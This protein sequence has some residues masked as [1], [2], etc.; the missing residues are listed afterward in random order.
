MNK[1]NYMT[2]RDQ[3]YEQ[4]NTYYDESYKCN[5]IK[6][7]NYEL[8]ETCCPLECFIYEGHYLCMACMPGC[9]TG[10]GWNELEFRDSNEE[11]VICL[12]NN[13]KQVKFPT[14]CGHW[15]CLSCSKNILFL[16]ETRY[17]LSP[18]PFGCSS[19]PNNC[20][21]PIKGKQ[22]YCEE[23]TE[24]QDKW[25]QDF[26]LEYKKW[27]DSENLSIDQGE[28]IPGSVFG[29]CTCPLCKKKYK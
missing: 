12:E 24:I 7:K 18:V 26:P 19:C 4:T 13:K 11:C 25:E 16:D 6:C 22:C 29:T 23:Y 15:F 9:G 20:I 2:Y 8:C 21:N 28:T 27:N 10:F 1:T 3:Q 14:N 17:H 5:R